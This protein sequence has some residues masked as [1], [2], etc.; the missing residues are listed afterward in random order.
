MFDFS[1]EPGKK[2]NKPY[3]AKSTQKPLV[4]IITPFYNAGTYFQQ[5]Y[6]SVVNQTFP[7]FE[8]IIVDDGSTE[9]EH[10]V[11]LENLCVSDNR[12]SLI[13]QENR[14]ISAARNTAI[15]AAST[16]IIIPLDADDLIVPTYIEV[17][18]WLLL[19]NPD[20]SWAYTN[21]VGFDGQQYLWNEKFDAERLKTYNFLTYCGAIRKSALEEVGLYDDS[22]KHYYEDWYLWLR[23]L[24]AGKKPVKSNLYGFWYRRL[25]TGVLSKVNNDP[26]I[27]EVAMQMI[28]KAASTT[29]TSLAAKE[30]PIIPKPNEFSLL[31]TS[32]WCRESPMNDTRQSIL[33]LIPWMKMGGAEVFELDILKQIN[34]EKF[35]LTVVTTVNATSEW[36]QRF[37]Q[38]TDDIFELSSFLDLA[39][40]PE[41]ISYLIK[42]RNIKLTMVT[43]SYY[44]YC[45]MPWMRR[46]FP[47]MAIIDYVHMEEMY[48][49]Q[50]GY[51]RISSAM[52]E[53]TEHTFVCNEHTRQ[54]MLS[55]FG[56]SPLE[57][58]TLYIGVDS[59]WYSSE[60]V[61]PGQ[62]YKEMNL[63]NDR[64]IVLFPCRMSA[65]K[66]PFLML[67]IAKEAKKRRLPF[68]FVVVGNGELLDSIKKEVAH[69]RLWDTVFFAGEQQDLRPYYKDAFVTLNCSIHEGLALTAYESCAMETPVITSDAGGQSELI[70]HTNG[71][72]LP[73]FQKSNT[74]FG[75]I[76]YCT[77]EIVQYVDALEEIYSDAQKYN[78]MCIACRQKIDSTFSTDIM[79]QK[80]EDA[81]QR[82][83]QDAQLAK[84]RHQISEALQMVPTMVDE[85][86]VQYHEIESREALYQ[87]TISGEAKNELMRIANSNVGKVLIKLFFRLHLNKLLK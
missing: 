64:P 21:T 52:K 87:N 19:K 62:C 61:K 28:Q 22:V 26:E 77:E 58:S 54:V 44:G 20:S 34:K 41:F 45:L 65:Q 9:I 36:R 76:Q 49:R 30:Y 17:L 8:W 4:T 67:E 10:M 75:T 38:Y 15:R 43:N 83:I 31:H 42:S 16:E 70:D 72:V 79:I 68:A 1:R 82:F 37:E 35:S 32:P 13:H 71:V 46:E 50:G 66:R 48:W 84:K 33:L 73:L 81:F 14:G 7:W 18:Y 3:V 74:D 80:L 2:L 63:A 57:V 40:Y 86:T 6:N 29:N 47:E 56:R 59:K 27:H 25:D 51:A 53:I 11:L 12:I 23:L 5:T 78:D 60:N 85:F 55:D 24:G 39:N 69:L